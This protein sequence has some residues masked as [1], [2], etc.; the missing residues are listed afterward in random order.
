MLCYRANLHKIKIYTEVPFSIFVLPSFKILKR[1]LLNLSHNRKYRQPTKPN[2][3]ILKWASYTI[4]I[5][6][7]PLY[8]YTH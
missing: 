6:A 8:K 5:V 1:Y 2:L 4:R 3:P 7:M